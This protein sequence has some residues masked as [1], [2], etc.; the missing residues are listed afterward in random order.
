MTSYRAEASDTMVWNAA[1][2]PL[3]EAEPFCCSPGCPECDETM[4]PPDTCKQLT[5]DALTRVGIAPFS[6]EGYACPDCTAAYGCDCAV[7]S[8]VGRTHREAMAERAER[9]AEKD[10]F[11]RSHADTRR[12]DPPRQPLNAKLRTFDA[13][14]DAAR[15]ELVR[16]LTEEWEYVKRLA[17]GRHASGH[18]LYGDALMYEYDQARLLVESV[19]ELADGV[20]YTVVRLSRG[21]DFA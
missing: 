19:E 2:A 14:A 5:E 9:H 18:F 15:D 6:P 11:L 21:G 13:L 16:L 1:N 20:N 8:P 17:A 10:L 12:Y 4:V 3:R 7:V